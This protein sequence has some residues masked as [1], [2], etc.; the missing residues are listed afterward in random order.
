MEWCLIDVW[1]CRLLPTQPSYSSAS[2]CAALTTCMWFHH[3]VPRRALIANS[4]YF[5]RGG[6]LFFVCASVVVVVRS[7]PGELFA[8]Y[9]FDVPLLRFTHHRFISSPLAWTG[10]A[11]VWTVLGRLL[12]IDC[13]L[14]GG[15]FIPVSSAAMCSHWPI[16]FLFDCCTPTAI[17]LWSL[18]WLLTVF[19]FDSQLIK[20]ELIPLCS[21][22]SC[23]ALL[24]RVCFFFSSFSLDI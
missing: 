24:G 14:S 5:F 21:D 8:V 19:K 4:I 9:N 17:C 7:V 12:T 11:S 3:H 2:V 15:A 13:I 18:H 6:L 22:A 16:L 23:S 20:L 10:S 1:N